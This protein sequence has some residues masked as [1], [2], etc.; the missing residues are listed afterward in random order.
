MHTDTTHVDSAEVSYQ[1]DHLSVR[2]KL[3]HLPHT[4]T[5]IPH[6]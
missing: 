5:Q 3:P 2:V 4:C 6:T 1:S